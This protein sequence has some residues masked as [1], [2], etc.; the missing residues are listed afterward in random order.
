VEKRTFSGAEAEG[1]LIGFYSGEELEGV[2]SHPGER[3]HVHYAGEDLQISGHLDSFGVR[4]GATLFL[5][6][7]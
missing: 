2:V 1:R 7:R 4:K 3:F 6:K 5:P